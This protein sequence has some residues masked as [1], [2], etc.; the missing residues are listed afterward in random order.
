[1]RQICTFPE[2]WGVPP[3]KYRVLESGSNPGFRTF[4]RT[5]SEIFSKSYWT[6]RTDRLNPTR[7]KVKTSSE[8]YPLKTESNLDR[9]LLCGLG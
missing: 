3:V 4:F 1:M 2:V 5:P 9:N 8:K 7:R 6:D